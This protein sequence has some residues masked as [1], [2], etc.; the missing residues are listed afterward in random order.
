MLKRISG[1]IHLHRY[2]DGKQEITLELEPSVRDQFIKAIASNS[3]TLVII[4]GVP[5]TTFRLES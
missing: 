2:R 5:L 1:K 4:E 3:T